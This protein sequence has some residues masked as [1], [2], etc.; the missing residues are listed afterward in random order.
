MTDL[1]QETLGVA[2]G[3]FRCHLLGRPQRVSE[4]GVEYET[5]RNGLVCAE[6]ASH[7]P[8]L[9]F[10]AARAAMVGYFKERRRAGYDTVVWRQLP[11]VSAE[12]RV[13]SFRLHFVRW[14]DVD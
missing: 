12:N 9:T 5:W 11:E 7:G 4:F 2:R 1:A 6:G 14:K 13:L 8:R 10:E 3:L